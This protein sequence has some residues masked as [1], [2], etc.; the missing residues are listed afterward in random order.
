MIFKNE[1]VPASPEIT[2]LKLGDPTDL[3]RSFFII[4]F[5]LQLESCELGYTCVVVYQIDHKLL[6]FFQQF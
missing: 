2:M 5:L 4:F 3:L 6:L 1:M